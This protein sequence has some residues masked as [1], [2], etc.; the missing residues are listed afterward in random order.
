[1]RTSVLWG[2][3]ASVTTDGAGCHSVRVLPFGLLLRHTTGPGQSSFHVLGTGISRQKATSHFGSTARFRLL[4]LPLWTTRTALPKKRGLASAENQ[5]NR[6]ESD[7]G[8]T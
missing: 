1:M 2:L 5:G 4:G 3:G 7:A 8:S 6:D